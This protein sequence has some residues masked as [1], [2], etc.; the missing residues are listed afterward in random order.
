M[1]D[2]LL[3]DPERAERMGAEGRERVRTQFLGAR[4]LLQYVDIIATVLA[5]DHD[6]EARSVG[7]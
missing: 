5:R 1:I 3:A 6:P 7:R 2:E 4:H